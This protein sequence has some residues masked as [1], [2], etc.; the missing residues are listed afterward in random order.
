VTKV[1]Y[2]TATVSRKILKDIAMMAGNFG[3]FICAAALAAGYQGGLF[4]F[5]V[6]C[7]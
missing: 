7:R 2:L 6:F 5:P 1:Q 3:L 4:S